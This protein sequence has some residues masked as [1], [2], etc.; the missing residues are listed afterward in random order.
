M[1]NTKKTQNPG[2]LVIIGV[3]L[4]VMIGLVRKC[5]NSTKTNTPAPV[6]SREYQIPFS[7]DFKKG[8]A[9]QDDLG[10]SIVIGVDTSGSM[11]EAGRRSAEPKY[12][13]ASKSLAEITDFLS[14]V[15]E[16]QFRKDNLKL[17]IGLLAFSSDVKELFPLT[18]MNA[19]EFNK[20]KMIV[21]DTDNFRPD[22]DTAIG[23]TMEK[24]T[25][26]LSQSGTIFRSLIIITDGENTK[27]IVPEK[28]MY[29][30]VNNK[31]NKNTPDFPVT[32]STI[33]TSFI[34][35]DLDANVFQELNKQGARV[36]S[37]FSREELIN[38][39]QNIFVAD[40]TKLESGN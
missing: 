34:G 28:V 14:G 16:T 1:S 33:L 5:N 29:A 25:E 38:S 36:T 17:K 37:A 11:G 7:D 31:N 32:T 3:I 40:I 18:E 35:F 21:K 13:V 22:G 2:G 8:L 6:V 24:G 9:A 39:L 23:K 15:Y 19:A 27:G 20:L 4:M 30:I 12:E 26:M 10:I